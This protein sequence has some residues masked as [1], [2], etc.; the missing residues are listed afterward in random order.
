MAKKPPYSWA[1]A[2]NV[3]WFPGL[4]KPAPGGGFMPRNPNLNLGPMLGISSPSIQTMNPRSGGGGNPYAGIINDYLNQTKANFGA[5]SAADAASRDAALRRYVISYGTVPDFNSLGISDSAKGF[6]EKAIDANTQALAAKNEAE[7]TSIHARM[8]NEN[9]V[10]NRRIPA[11]LAARGLLRSGQTGSDLRDQAQAHKIRGFDTLNEMLQGVEGTV[12]SFLN[13]ERER[14]M[15]LAEAEMNAR[16]Q[17]M[18]DWGGDM[19]GDG[20]GLMPNDSGFYDTRK[21][22]GPKVGYGLNYGR[23]TTPARVPPPRT[24]VGGYGAGRAN[25]PKRGQRR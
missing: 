5:Q 19:Y 14:Q 25:R 12:G 7:G 22:W 17:A 24:V 9:K 11:Q 23:P 20:G 6:W 18:G 13:A 1:G 8:E 2:A 3:N 15:A 21:L 16:M 4:N 10:A